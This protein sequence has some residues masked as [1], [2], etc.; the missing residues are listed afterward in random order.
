MIRLT[1]FICRFL[2]KDSG[3][4]AIEYAM[5]AFMIV[6]VLSAAAY[7][8]GDEVEALYQSVTTIQWT[9]D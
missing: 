2:K 3:A 6:A 7:V 1:P 4:T 8:L 9:K 5:I